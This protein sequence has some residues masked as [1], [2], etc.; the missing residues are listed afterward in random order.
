MVTTIILS[1]SLF[2]GL[3]NHIEYAMKG[4]LKNPIFSV[5]RE[6]KIITIL[7]QSNFNKRNTGF[8]VFSLLLQF[9]YMLI[10]NKRQFS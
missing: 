7:K 3:D 5:L 8:P 9:V 10:V 1:G 4:I 2:V 6:I